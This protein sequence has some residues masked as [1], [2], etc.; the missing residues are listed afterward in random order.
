[1]T[2]SAFFCGRRI[3]RVIS[4]FMTRKFEARFR[5]FSLV[6]LGAGVLSLELSPIAAT[7][8]SANYQT[9]T[10]VIDCGGERAAGG[11][12]SLQSSIGQT[13][14]A[15]GSNSDGSL[16][17]TSG[18]IPQLSAVVA[19]RW[20]LYNES[21]W[22]GND[23]R[24]NA[25]D[26]QAIAS[27]K[28]AL[29]PGAM[30]SFD[31]YTSY[32]KG[33]NG[34]ILDVI[35][36]SAPPTAAD[37]VLKM[38][39]DSSPASWAPAP[40]PNSISVR[41]GAGIHGSDRITLIWPNNSLQQLWLEVTALANANT[42]LGGDDVF[43]F[44]NAIGE[45]GDDLSKAEVLVQD[46][47]RVMNHLSLTASLN[48]PYDFDRDKTV[49]VQDALQA[50]NHL[51]VGSSALQLIHVNRAELSTLAGLDPVHHALHKTSIGSRFQSVPLALAPTEQAPDSIPRIRRIV[52]E[53]QGTSP[54]VWLWLDRAEPVTV[55]S[56]RS[57]EQPDWQPIAAS[58]VRVHPGGLLEVELP[59]GRAGERAFFQ[60]STRPE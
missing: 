21:A 18:F 51:T 12:Y 32:S 5:W 58:S 59:I 53:L 20:V 35:E 1:M 30:A 38:G 45:T 31:N 52:A 23:P 8:T 26:D 42:G 39:N 36:L 3:E 43:Y 15:T 55:S 47:V 27:D 2:V 22:D 40:A 56:T 16:Q 34:I 41:W 11:P 14:S 25:S 4:C 37:F 57:L 9:T 7:R 24:A 44:G 10:E 6:C 19:G 33:L 60:L 29:L 46:A 13:S 50:M 17:Y 48:N 54:R 49:L 28:T